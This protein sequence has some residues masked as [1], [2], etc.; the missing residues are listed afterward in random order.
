MKKPFLLLFSL[1]FISCKVTLH[2]NCYDKWR[3]YH[4][5]IDEKDLFGNDL[6]VSGSDI[7]VSRTST[8]Y[9]QKKPQ[10]LI[11]YLDIYNKDYINAEY[12]I[13]NKNKIKITSCKRKEFIGEYDVIL[14]E[15]QV[16]F[17]EIKALEYN[18]ILKSERC[19]FYLKRYIPLI[20]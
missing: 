4:L 13:L 10:I 19:S 5:I 7:P 14:T 2:E 18:L 17:P 6:K 12:E 3:M 20:K 9:I 16:D 15:K 1:L 8:F 11:I